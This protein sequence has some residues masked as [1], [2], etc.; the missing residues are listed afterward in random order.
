M[1]ISKC[2]LLLAILSTILSGCGYT[3]KDATPMNAQE[4]EADLTILPKSEYYF[5]EKTNTLVY[6]AK[7]KDSKTLLYN[8]VLLKNG[9]EKKNILSLPSIPYSFVIDGDWIYFCSKAGSVN[10]D[11]DPNYSKKLRKL[12]KISKFFGDSSYCNL[13]RGNL[14]TKEIQWLGSS[15]TYVLD[16]K[17]IYFKEAPID[18]DQYGLGN[19]K[20]CII[21][22]NSLCRMDKDGSNPV[23]VSIEKYQILKITNKYIYTGN[24]R[25]DKSTFREEIQSEYD[26]TKNDEVYYLDKM[27]YTK[28]A[29]NNKKTNVYCYDL[30]TKTTEKIAQYTVPPK[31]IIPLDN[32]GLLILQSD[33]RNRETDQ[34]SK[35][36]FFNKEYKLEKTMEAKG[37]YHITVRGNNVYYILEEINDGKSILSYKDG[38]TYS[39]HTLCSDDLSLQGENIIKIDIIDDSAR[40]W[41]GK[42]GLA[43]I[44]ATNSK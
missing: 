32:G 37:R 9:E 24:Y 11:I 33:N 17:H 14:E 42:T 29:S 25:I 19:P 30:N 40:Y 15:N 39:T 1:K 21:S 7:D 10:P 26:Y 13:F 6:F 2:I 36:Y 23:L 5:D 41:S 3:P 35:I 22:D 31:Q 12:K 20:G 28:R 27:F 8:L 16:D 38:D 34:V 44:S 43:I 18:S 4:A